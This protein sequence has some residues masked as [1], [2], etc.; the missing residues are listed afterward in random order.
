MTGH[1]APDPDVELRDS[2]RAEE[3]TDPPPETAV[4]WPFPKPARIAGSRFKRGGAVYVWLYR[5]YE[6]LLKAQ[7]EPGFAWREVAYEA[8][9]GICSP[10]VFQPPTPAQVAATWKKV[11]ASVRRCGYDFEK[12]AATVF[13]GDG[14]ARDF[15]PLP[16]PPAPTPTSRSVAKIMAA[17]RQQTDPRRSPVYRWMLSNYAELREALEQDSPNWGAVAVALDKGGLTDRDGNPPA[18]G[19]VAQTWYRVRRAV[20]RKAARDAEPARPPVAVQLLRPAAGR[21]AEPATGAVSP[22]SR[23]SPP[24]PP[25]PSQ[26]ASAAMTVEARLRAFRAGL[27][28]GKVRIPEPINPANPRGNADGET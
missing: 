14:A 7:A 4:S 2:R 13:P 17:A 20:M 28:A 27:N 1:P 22:P 21:A 9:K 8:G 18:P 6:A 15:P 16:P 23:P 24:R 19:T 5:Q 12:W 3:T 26:A 25:E 10:D 11:C